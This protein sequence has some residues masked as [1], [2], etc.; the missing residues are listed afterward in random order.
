MPRRPQCGSE[1]TIAWLAFFSIGIVLIL[2]WPGLTSGEAG[3]DGDTIPRM[4]EVW[5]WLGLG[6]L[7]F[8]LAWPIGFVPAFVAAKFFFRVSFF[9]RSST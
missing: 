3:L 7:T 2:G 9:I 8:P 6:E 4:M 1:R 5:L